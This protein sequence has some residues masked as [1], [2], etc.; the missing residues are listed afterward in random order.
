MFIPGTQNLIKDTRVL[1]NME[2][3]SPWGRLAT[4]SAPAFDLCRLFDILIAGVALLFF[5]P[6][7]IAVAFAIK[8]EDGGPVLFGQDRIGYG[9]RTFKCWKFRSMVTDAEARLTAVLA[10]DPEARSQWETYRK[11]RKD[12]RV[13]A[14]GAFLRKTSLDELPQLLNIFTGEMSVVGPRP[15]MIVELSLYGR[16]IKNYRT[17]RPGLTGLWQVSGRNHLSFRQRVALDKLYVR[18]AGP[19]MY[20]TL[21]FRTIPAVLLRS[22][23]Y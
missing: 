3:P 7:M 10:N 18:D 12:P 8:L 2:L 17:V 5:A 14:I 15:I 19:K 6:L 20:L 23:S 11:L 16:W 1:R 9:G 13:T 21:L 4:H 22:G